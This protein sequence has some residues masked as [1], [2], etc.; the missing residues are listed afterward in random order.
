M[1]T[2][3]KLFALAVTLFALANLL[4]VVSDT[5]AFNGVSSPTPAQIGLGKL[6]REEYG[7]TVTYS[8]TTVFDTN[9]G[10]S[11]SHIETS[12]VVYSNENIERVSALLIGHM[13][14]FQNYIN[15]VYNKNNGLVLHIQ[16]SDFVVNNS[17]MRYNP[18]N[19]VGPALEVYTIDLDTM[20]ITTTPQYLWQAPD[21]DNSESSTWD[22]IYNFFTGTPPVNT[23]FVAPLQVPLIVNYKDNTYA[24]VYLGT[25]E[26]TYT[27]QIGTTPK[28]I[29]EPAQAKA[30][31]PTFSF[32]G[33]TSFFVKKYPDAG[34]N[35]SGSFLVQNDYDKHFETSTPFHPGIDLTNITTFENPILYFKTTDNSIYSWD[36]NCNDPHYSTCRFDFTEQ[37]NY[38]AGEPGVFDP[39]HIRCDIQVST[40][41]SQNSS[42]GSTS[43]GSTSNDSYSSGSST[44]SSSTIIFESVPQTCTG[45]T[46]S[47]TTTLSG[48]SAD[49]QP[50]TCTWRTYN[51]NYSCQ[52]VNGHFCTTSGD[53]CL[54]QI[55]NPSQYT[56]SGT[57]IYSGDI[58]KFSCA[59]TT[60]TCTWTNKNSCGPASACYVDGDY[61]RVNKIV[62][63]ISI[64]SF[65]NTAPGIVNDLSNPISGTG[66]FNVTRTG[67][68]ISLVYLSG[69]EQKFC[70]LFDENGNFLYKS[71]GTVNFNYDYTSPKF[72]KYVNLMLGY[73]SRLQT[74]IFEPLNAVLAVGSSFYPPA[75]NQKI[76]LMGIVYEIDYQSFLK[77]GN[78]ANTTI[79]PFK[80]SIPLHFDGTKQNILDY[81]VLFFFVSFLLAIISLFVFLV[82]LK[83]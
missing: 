41:V 82:N 67:S 44:T 6:T 27:L 80:D 24:F 55:D 16:T 38:C 64:P 2:N 37:A 13:N 81:F 32:N 71:A 47:G 28:L 10:I 77:L 69:S 66:G 12:S 53:A 15:F 1:K 22:S 50:N 58:T 4:H 68:S 35:S 51:S 45:S 26:Y 79:G 52:D 7:V 21:I 78:D 3:T 65:D 75:Q 76:C 60:Q 49:L 29:R 39:R 14:Q 5:N 43:S 11:V 48:T 63:P 31:G 19:A 17:I 30:I 9:G 33:N 73:L 36:L 57:S 40:T 20:T 18:T 56:G 62:K 42:T 8:G 72:N 54:Q 25:D 83:K 61:C 74:F 23:S 59:S 34:V 70:T 46:F